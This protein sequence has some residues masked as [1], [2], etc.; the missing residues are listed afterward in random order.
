MTY[1]VADIQ[2]RFGVSQGTVLHWLAS[3][4]LKCLNVGRDPGKKRARYRV[5]QG[6]LDSFEALRQLAPP[7]PTTRR[8]RRKRQDVEFY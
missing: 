8:R 6:Q 4:Q 1:S 3:G 7:P 5:T 2:E